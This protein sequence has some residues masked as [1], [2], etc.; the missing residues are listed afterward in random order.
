MG[1]MVPGLRDSDQKFSFDSSCYGNF[2][3]CSV[4]HASGFMLAMYELRLHYV[5]QV[6]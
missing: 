1:T 5:F 6:M 4:I 3:V 2:P